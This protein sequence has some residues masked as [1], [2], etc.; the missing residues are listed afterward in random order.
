MRFTTSGHT[1]LTYLDDCLQ[2][3]NTDKLD[4]FITGDMNVNCKNRLSRDF[5]RLNFSIKS[6]GLTQ[7]ITRNTDKTNSLIDLVISNSKFISQAGTLDH[8]IS[9]HQPIY[10]VHKKGRDKRSPVQFMGR[11]YRNYDKE[12]FRRRLLWADW[13]D[14]YQNS[15]PESAWDSI[16]RHI[17]TVLDDMCP[18]RTF[19]IKN[20]I[21]LTGL[22]RS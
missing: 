21:G 18:L 11:S 14:F 5:K 7:H 15:D 12:E 6:H 16:L 2:S 20:Y 1:P 3:V 4:L 22:H 9:D 10:V 17:T 13:A 8:F 19:H